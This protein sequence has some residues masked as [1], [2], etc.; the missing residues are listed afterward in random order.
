MKNLVTLSTLGLLAIFGA[1]AAHADTV[2]PANAVI[3]AAGTQ[4]AQT[5]DGTDPVGIPVSGATSYTFAATGLITLN[6]GTLNDPDGVG[7]ATGSSSNSGSGSISGI[8]APDAGYLVGVF[9]GAGGPTGTAPASLDYSA[10]G[11]TGFTSS[12][13]LLNQ[14]FF[15]GDGLTGDGTGTAQTFYVPTGA[16]T[17]YFGIS[18]ACG[19]NGGPGCYDDNHGQFSIAVNPTG[20]STS[21][22]PEPS[23]LMLF[24]TGILGAAGAIRRRLRTA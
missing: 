8:S 24:G 2:V 23:N 13:P 18:D 22:V 9:I 15:I 12:S 1:S 10:A 11:A 4:S 19:Y 6:N 20:S 21:T 3:Y 7:A 17:L 5:A 14:V 16:V